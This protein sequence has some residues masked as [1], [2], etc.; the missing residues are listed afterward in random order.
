MCAVLVRAT[1]W[2]WLCLQVGLPYSISCNDV[3]HSRWAACSSPQQLQALGRYSQD[4]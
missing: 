1:K 4:A 2:V 3:R